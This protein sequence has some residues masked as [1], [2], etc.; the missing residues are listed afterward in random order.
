[1]SSSRPSSSRPTLAVE[2]PNVAPST[3]PQKA[4]FLAGFNSLPP[5]GLAEGL[6]FFFQTVFLLSPRM[7]QLR[8]IVF[9][10]PGHI[11]RLNLHHRRPF[12]AGFLRS[13]CSSVHGRGCCR[14]WS[15]AGRRGLCRSGLRAH[16]SLRHFPPHAMAQAHARSGASSRSLTASL[17]HLSGCRL[18]LCTMASFEVDRRSP[19][20]IFRR[21]RP[22]DRSCSPS[23]RVSSW[24]RGSWCP[25][26]HRRS[27]SP[28]VGC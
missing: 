27:C 26:D 22:L 2:P 28:P 18:Q 3:K 13:S 15:G 12:V 20:L 6:S 8:P 10:P 9:P 5:L 23:Q 21:C 11:H 4:P 14:P 19:K 25:R 16:P 1:M 7:S 24:D 17:A